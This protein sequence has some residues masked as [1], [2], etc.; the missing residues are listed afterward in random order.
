MRN[1]FIAFV[2]LVSVSSVAQQNRVLSGVVSDTLNNR[3]I[4]ANILAIP[5]SSKG[6]MQ[7]SITDEQGRYKLSLK[8]NEAYNIQVSYLGFETLN[9]PIA[10]SDEDIVQNFKLQVQADALEEVL[11]SYKYEPVIVK[12]DTLLYDVSAFL[13][14]NERKMKDVLKNLPNVEV[15]K[16]GLVRV[17][18]K[19]V[20]HLL[21]EGRTFFGGGTKLAV[22]NIPAD[23]IDKIEVIDHFNEVEFLKEVSNSQDL[24][25]NVQLKEDKKKLLFGDIEAGLGNN[26]HYLLHAG[27]FYYTPEYDISFIADAN[28]L[29]KSTFT[30]A[31]AIRFEGGA[32]RLLN[33][34]QNLSNLRH[35]VGDNQ[36]VAKNTTRFSAVNFSKELSDKLTLSS[37]AVFSNNFIQNKTDK[38]IRYFTDT[39]DLVEY[40]QNQI[41]SKA[42]L[43]LFNLK[44]DYER[45]K[46]ERLFY[47]AYLEFD[48]PNLKEDLRRQT[49][50]EEIIFNNTHK[51][52]NVSFKQFLEWHKSFNKKHISSAIIQHHSGRNNPKK[53]WLSNQKFLSSLLPVEEAVF[54][55]LQQIE[56]EETHSLNALFK[57]H[58]LVHSHHH[59]Y[60]NLGL[61]YDYVSILNSTGQKLD[62]NRYND[63][64]S[65]SFG[66]DMNY[67]LLNSYI[68]LDY[69]FLHKSWTHTASLSL[70]HY[71]LK[72]NQVAGSFKQNHI[73]FEPKWHSKWEI[74]SSESLNFRYSYQNRFPYAR[75]LSESFVLQAYN[76]IYRGNALLK[77]EKFHSS[78]ISYRKFNSYRGLSIYANLYY[79]RRERSIRNQVILDGVDRYNSAFMM[80]TPETNWNFIGRI[81]K[82]VKFIRL[83]LQPIANYTEFTQ[84][85]NTKLQ[86]TNT[87]GVGASWSIR[88]IWKYNFDVDFMF[89]KSFSK[90]SST[91]KTNYDSDRIELSLSYDFFK[92]WQAKASYEYYKNSNR[93]DKTSRNYNL[94]EFSL[95]YNL[96][97]SAWSF[98]L[99][100]QNL[101]NNKTKTNTSFSDYYLMEQS[102]YVLPRIVWFGIQYKL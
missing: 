3:L 90:Y 53:S 33:N 19:Q 81:E 62:N 88:S 27:L 61:D 36:D 57:H 87:K 38:E 13:K 42:L 35:Y 7:F 43:G 76:S 64:E 101:W 15:D 29:G 17:Q 94:S 60:I 45:S 41:D 24:A 2:L 1:V 79:N 14:G 102:T 86:N 25:M 68:N 37:Y 54:Y 21:V 82:D 20:T 40:N 74:G 85:V 96:S 91:Q 51:A 59:L 6:N 77:N 97:Q 48:K 49:I 89:T 11:I 31:D 66:E 4:G 26:T 12:K 46:N 58:W 18:G 83:G 16:D 56:K 71:G 72:H 30:Y 67:R 52:Q 55:Y 10:K 99:A 32:N 75:H 84:A 98:E 69:K 44:L 5:E 28:T 9:L 8:N 65:S 47:N 23:A 22:E 63:F 92:N 80:D 73:K 93:T 50:S 70:H 39:Q 100:A 78:S 95:R 34:R